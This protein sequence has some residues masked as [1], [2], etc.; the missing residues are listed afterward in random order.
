[1][2]ETHDHHID[3]DDAIA[4]YLLGQSSDEERAAVQERLFDDEDYFNRIRA[5]EY[6]LLDAYSRGEMPVSDRAL[7]ES[8]LL[9]SEAGRRKL[10]FARA[11]DSVR[12]R[13]RK[14]P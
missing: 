3:N 4:R 8:S 12:K 9:G 10:D 13:P 5:A 1:M 2:A 14:H 6:E 11:F 7:V